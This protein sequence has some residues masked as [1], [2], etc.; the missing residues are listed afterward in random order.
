MITTVSRKWFETHSNSL[1]KMRP[2][3]LLLPRLDVPFEKVVPYPRK[4]VISEGQSMHP[5]KMNFKMNFKAE[6]SMTMLSWNLTMPFLHGCHI[7]KL[8]YQKEPHLK[9]SDQMLLL[10][11][12]GFLRVIKYEYKINEGFFDV[13]CG[14]PRKN[15]ENLHKSQNPLSFCTLSWLFFHCR[16]T[17]HYY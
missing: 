1:E 11:Y 2:P 9:K 14:H 7:Y 4:K 3:S 15:A 12:W 5:M 6:D 17:L 8:V 13:K 16:L 10:L